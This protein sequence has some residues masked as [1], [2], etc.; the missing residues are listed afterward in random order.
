[1]MATREMMNIGTMRKDRLRKCQPQEK[2]YLNEREKCGD[3]II[4]KS[5]QKYGNNRKSD[6]DPYRRDGVNDAHKSFSRVP[7]QKV[8]LIYAG[9]AIWTVNINPSR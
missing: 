4:S 7:A 2:Q 5:A 8:E 9:K 1:M 3:A 6:N